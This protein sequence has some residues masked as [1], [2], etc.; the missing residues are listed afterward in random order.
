MK[1]THIPSSTLPGSTFMLHV[2]IQFDCEHLPT[3]AASFITFFRLSIYL[4]IC[5][6]TSDVVQTIC[7][8]N[9]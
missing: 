3:P 8:A 4:S 7:M 5:I 6:R 2:P 1:S 9:R